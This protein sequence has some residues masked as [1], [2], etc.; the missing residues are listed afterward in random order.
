LKVPL[1]MVR[2]VADVLN[3][4]GMATAIW[5]SNSK[6]LHSCGGAEPPGFF[7]GLVHRT[8]G[9]CSTKLRQVKTAAELD[10]MIR[11]RT[12][13]TAEFRGR[14]LRASS[15][16]QTESGRSGEARWRIC[17]R[18]GA[19]RASHSILGWTSAASWHPWPT[20]LK[21]TAGM[22]DPPDWGIRWTGTPS[23]SPQRS[24]GRAS[25]EQRDTFA[26]LSDAR[27]TTWFR[28]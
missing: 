14:Q 20:G 7:Q 28:R 5:R 8:V 17:L 23:D 15:C 18:I 19:W 13:L 24:G 21:L 22:L 10:V 1:D 16:G 6:S 27:T 25:A 3:D 12:R 2:V 4:R 11:A 9:R 26:R